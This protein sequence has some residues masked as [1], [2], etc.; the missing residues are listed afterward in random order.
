MHQ[1]LGKSL[2]YLATLANHGVLREVD[3]DGTSEAKEVTSA[4]ILKSR[5]S[6]KTE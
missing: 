6:V 1:I 4:I 2:Y 3:T 5:N